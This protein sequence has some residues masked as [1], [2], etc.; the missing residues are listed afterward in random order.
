MYD[1]NPLL[2][3]LNIDDLAQSYQVKPATHRNSTF[4]SR[5]TSIAITLTVVVAAVFVTNFV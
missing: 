4:L 1:Q 5:L 3:K 2:H